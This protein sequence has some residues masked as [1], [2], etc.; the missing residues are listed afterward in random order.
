MVD[1]VDDPH[2]DAPLVG[3]DERLR[4]PL[5]GL[6]AQVDVVEGELEC[7]LRLGEERDRPGGH[8]V[9]GLPAV[10]E[11]RELDQCGFPRIRVWFSALNRQPGNHSLQVRANPPAVAGTVERGTWWERNRGTAPLSA[12]LR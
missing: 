4:H 10:T 6:L 11:G 8:L 1:V 3:G 2:L 5:L 12:G 9:C 7:P